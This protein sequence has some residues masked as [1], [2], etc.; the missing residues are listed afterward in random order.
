MWNFERM[1]A[2]FQFLSR[3]M[4]TQ[5]VFLDNRH[6]KNQM[7]TRFVIDIRKEKSF[8]RLFMRT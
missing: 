6:H 3:E 4:E 5:R 8:L 1:R 2:I 7:I